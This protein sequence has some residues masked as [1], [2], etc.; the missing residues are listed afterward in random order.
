LRGRRRGGIEV[1]HARNR[2]DVN[3]TALFTMV[4]LVLGWAALTCAALVSGRLPTFAFLVLAVV[5][6]YLAVPWLRLRADGLDGSSRPVRFWTNI[7][8]LVVSLAACA[9]L[10]VMLARRTG[11][12]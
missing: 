4:G 7:A 10:G 2:A 3:A 9:A 8:M 1:R 6:L 5:A 12:L 11:L